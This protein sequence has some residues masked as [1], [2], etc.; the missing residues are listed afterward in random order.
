[1]RRDVR[2]H[3]DCD[4]GGSVDQQVREPTRQDQRF[5]AALVVV[6]G[7]VDRVLIDT[8]QH[9]DGYRSEPALG[10][11]HRSRRVV[12]RRAEVALTVD[13][14]KPHRPRLGK[15]HQ[16]VVDRGVAVRVVLPHHVADDPAA[17][18]VT[19]VGPVA[20]VV[21]RVQDATVH[22]LESVANIRQRARDD[23]RHRVVEEAALHLDLEADRLYSAS[24]TADGRIGDLRCQG[25][26]HPSRCG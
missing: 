15:A 26:A 4:A 23:D 8:A 1:V 9:L 5:L 3:P 2:G 16:G 22:R 14:R 24:A 12:A 20:T 6:R 10:V 21:H 7:E 11:A 18:R 17:L 25:S 19:A 13:E